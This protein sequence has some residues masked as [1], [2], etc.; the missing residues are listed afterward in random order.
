MNPGRIVLVVVFAALVG[1]AVWVLSQG[2]AQEQEGRRGGELT[3]VTTEVENRTFTDI[4]EALGTARASESVTLNSRVS[5]TVRDVKFDD[6]QLV[7]KGDVLVVLEDSEEKAQLSEA[8][9][10]LKEAERQF[11]RTSDLVKQGNA[12]TA[13]LDAQQRNLDEAR[14]RLDAARARLADQR[15]VAPFDG[16]L[17]LRQISPGSLITTTTAI[18]TIDAIDLIYL[19]FSVPERFIATMA[20]GQTV[21]AKVEAYPD[22]LFQGKVKTVDSRV[23]PITRSVIVRAEIP[24][25]DR[26]LR[27]G[28]LMRVEVISRTWQGIAVPEEAVVPT[29]GHNYVFV[30]ENGESHRRQVTLGLRRPGYVEVTEG[31][32]LGDRVVVEGTL[33]LGSQPAKVREVGAPKVAAAAQSSGGVL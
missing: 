31:L 20:P 9:A 30:V 23:D 22:R 17:G 33:R 27:P 24:N 5:D 32:T 26:L 11:N 3:V 15:I 1:S 13:A 29:G 21:E 28:I 6:G 8:E 4:V 14:F 16:L 18:T 25:K 12:S 10:N 19:D 2:P 7:N